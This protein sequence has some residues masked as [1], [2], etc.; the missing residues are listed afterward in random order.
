MRNQLESARR[1]GVR[2]ETIN[3]SNLDNWP[4]IRAALLQNE[5]DILLISPERLANEDFLTN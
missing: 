2:A 3:S 1:I 4:R 5:V